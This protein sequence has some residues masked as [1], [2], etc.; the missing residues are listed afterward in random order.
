MKCSVTCLH[1]FSAVVAI[2][3]FSKLLNSDFSYW[4][5]NKFLKNKRISHIDS[6]LLLENQSDKYF[7]G[8]LGLV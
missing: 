6:D 1:L 5:H 3:L 4:I 2:K 8:I 7:N